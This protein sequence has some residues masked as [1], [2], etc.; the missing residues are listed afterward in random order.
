MTDYELAAIHRQKV[1][2][3]LRSNPGAYG[4]D[5]VKII[6]MSRSKGG[7]ILFSMYEMGEVT[8]QKTI[9]RSV[10]KNGRPN[11]QASY[12][13]VAVVEKTVGFEEMF[14]RVHGEVKKPQKT[15]NPAVTR[16]VDPNR[17][18]IRNQ[19]GQGAAGNNSWMRASS[20]NWV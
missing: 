7:A 20:P 14:A 1:L 18:P 12:T 15:V 8:R 2:D 3:Y 19:G 6:G 10:D 17:S 13:Y 9:Y 4:P 16:N 5:I 11:A